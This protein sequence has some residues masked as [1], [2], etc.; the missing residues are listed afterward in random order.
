ML[1][2]WGT[3]SE[4]TVNKWVTLLKQHGDVHDQYNLDWSAQKIKN[5]ITTDFW[6]ELEREFDVNVTGPELLF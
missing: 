2:K 4:D 5:C 6:F 3:V 1:D